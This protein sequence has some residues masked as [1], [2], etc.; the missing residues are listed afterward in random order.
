MIETN[1]VFTTPGSAAGYFYQAR[2]ALLECL[3]FLYEETGIEVAIERFD[4]VSFE[5][6]GQPLELLQTKHH[7]KSQGDLTDMSV[8]LWK[9]LRIWS[10]YP[11]DDPSLPGRIRLALITT[12]IAPDGSAASFLRAPGQGPHERNPAEAE[13]LLVA[14]AQ[15]STNAVLKPAFGAFLALA[16]ELRRALV[17]AIE[18]IDSAPVLTDLE[19]AI[20]ERLK[21][22][23]PRGKHAQ[24]RERLE[25]WWW[26]RI[27]KALQLG[28]TISITELEAKIDDIRDMMKRDA[29]PMDME[30]AEPGADEL[31]AFDEMTFVRQLHTIGTGNNRIEFAKR[32]YYRAFTQRSRWTRLNLLF[33]GEMGLFEKQ[34]IEEWGPRFH[35]MC[36]D[37]EEGAD[38]KSVQRAGQD[39]YHWVETQARFPFRTVTARFITVGSYHMLSNEERVGWHRDYATLVK[40]P[41]GKPDGK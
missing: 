9:T 13:A 27:L 18:V 28:G 10:E 31:T 37:L 21:L 19:K 36:E 14:A 30:H 32:D 2:L 4:D 25:G 12:A 41:E 33:D 39:L 35:K 23:A 24:A 22:L 29:L 15:S 11:K 38:E 40:N 8:D 16:P 7:I 3:R 34:L 6:Q 17:N 20:E 1:S 5:K 26:P